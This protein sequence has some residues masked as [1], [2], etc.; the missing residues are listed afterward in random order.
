[1]RELPNLLGIDITYR[2]VDLIRFLN[3]TNPATLIISGFTVISVIT[4]WRHFPVLS[5]P[6]FDLV[7]GTV[8]YY[9]VQTAFPGIITG[10]VIG[11]IRIDLSATAFIGVSL[12]AFDVKLAVLVLPKVLFF[13]M[14]L[15]LISSVETLWDRESAMSPLRR[16][17]SCHRRGLWSDRLQI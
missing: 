4:A 3:L 15:C 11:D 9:I 17:A 14:I 8:V 16:S 5:P 2:F 12:R 6:F 10:R 13:R 7:S 1:L